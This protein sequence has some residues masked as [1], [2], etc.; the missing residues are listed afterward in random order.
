MYAKCCALPE[1]RDSFFELPE[2]N[3]VSWNTMISGY[4][5]Y[6]PRTHALQCFEQMK[7]EG[8]SPN[9]ATIAS[10]FKVC[11]AMEAYS[12]GHEIHMM[13]L[14]LKNKKDKNDDGCGADD[15]G[16]CHDDSEIGLCV[17]NAL[18]GMYSRRGGSCEAARVVFDGLVDRDVVSWTA[19][20][21][22]FA[23]HGLG[24]EGIKCWEQMQLKGVSPNAITFVNTLGACASIRDSDKGEEI[25]AEIERKGLISRNPYIHSS[26]VAM[27]AKCRCLLDAQEVFN[28]LTLSDSISWT[29]LM[30]GYSE[31]G[32][33]EKSLSLF[34]AHGY[35]LISF[36][37]I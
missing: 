22:G 19:L 7:F 18:I 35:V 30:V 28:K 34:E 3:V 6:G 17:G 5:E 2:R 1:A 20:I 8:F 10:M 13:L 26:L 9:D 25:H 14:M 32:Y 37:L 21:S 36:I 12:K 29:A 33:E 24:N 16:L 11:G 27:Y 4:A 15:D 31:Y 23:E